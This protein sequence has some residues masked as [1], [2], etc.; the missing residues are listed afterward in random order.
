MDK[1][2]II[3]LVFKNIN[4]SG[5]FADALDEVLEPA[6]KKIV[7]DSENTWDDGLMMVYPMLEEQLKILITEEINK[8]MAKLLE[9]T[10]TEPTGEQ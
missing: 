10:E 6:L 5:L 8:L 1:E 7:E 2:K 4:L 3:K 9:D